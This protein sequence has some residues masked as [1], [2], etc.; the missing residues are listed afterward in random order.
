MAGAWTS[1]RFPQFEPAI[2]RLTEQHRELKDE[3]LHLAI[4]YLP[5]R[6]GREVHDGVYLFEVIGG[7][8]DRFGE[9]GELHET[10]FE[11]V[12]GLPTGFNQTLHL[13]L[14]TPRE[15]G[16]AL[17]NGWALALEVA[18]AVR[19]EDFQVLFADRIG[20]Q[21]LRRIRAAVTPRKRATRE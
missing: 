13:I 16:T 2:R 1:E 18:D 3:P 20:Q 21:V 12:S 6:K 7:A 4:A 17:E 10:A 15:L 9:S 8:V 19:R 5:M 11:A 14:T